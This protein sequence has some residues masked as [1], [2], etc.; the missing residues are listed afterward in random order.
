MLNMSMGV[1]AGDG[2]RVWGPC[3]VRSK[4][5]KFEH[6]WRMLGLG[7]NVYCSQ[8]LCLGVVGGGGGAG[9]GGPCKMRS[10]ASWMMIILDP[11]S[12]WTE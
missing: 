9:P 12:L 3:T 8:V 1:Q 6:V 7:V 5:N 11:P 4:L 10:N 2:A